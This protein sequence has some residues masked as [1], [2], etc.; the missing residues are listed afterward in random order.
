MNGI[1]FS[2]QKAPGGGLGIFRFSRP[3]RGTFSKPSL[4]YLQKPYQK[5][6][7]PKTRFAQEQ[8]PKP[9]PDTSLDHGFGH[10]PS[11]YGIHRQ[12]NKFNCLLYSV[13]N[14]RRCPNQAHNLK[15]LMRLIDRR[16]MEMG[17][18][19][20]PRGG[21]CCILNRPLYFVIFIGEATNY[22]SFHFVR[23][24]PCNFSLL[25]TAAFRVFFRLRIRF[26][27]SLRWAK[28]MG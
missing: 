3:C 14:N 19:V 21:L 17:L 13:E 11:K 15:A 2:S 28:G 8:F 5:P 18:G 1:G 6:K 10:D 9:K 20:R 23:F 4:F 27:R 25:H 26:R 22:M 12:T 7:N 24:F 16:E